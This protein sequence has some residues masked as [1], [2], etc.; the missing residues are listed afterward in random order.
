MDEPLNDSKHRD[1]NGRPGTRLGSPEHMERRRRGL[2]REKEK[3]AKVMAVSMKEIGEVIRSGAV[4]PELAPYLTQ[5]K[6]LVEQLLV[7]HGAEVNES[8]NV[9]DLGEVSTAKAILIENVGRLALAISAL[10]VRFARTGDQEAATRLGSLVTAQ[11]V[12]A[13]RWEHVR[14]GDDAN[15]RSRRL[16]VVENLPQGGSGEGEAPKSG[17][18]R[19]VALSRRLRA[20]LAELREERF[21]EDPALASA[22]ARI[23]HGVDAHNFRRRRVQTARAAKARGEGSVA[24]LVWGVWR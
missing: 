2:K 24:A 17:L 3:R 22:E 6:H 15:D 11:R 23:F 19:E 8:G 4:R 12:R 7:D 16:Q 18:G 9:V 14:W 13:L 20:A 5:S 21:S 10:T 1:A